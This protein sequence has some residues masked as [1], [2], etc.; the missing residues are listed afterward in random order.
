V[1][2]S[3]RASEPSS[4]SAGIVTSAEGVYSVVNRE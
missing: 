2:R 1:S 4:G 3:E